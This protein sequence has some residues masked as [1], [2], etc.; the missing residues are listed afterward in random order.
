MICDTTG[1]IYYILYLKLLIDKA[2]IATVIASTL[3][4]V[5]TKPLYLNL[6][7]EPVLQL[8]LSSL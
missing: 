3:M 6:C 2:N 1:E 7:G 5:G 4:Y 8:Q